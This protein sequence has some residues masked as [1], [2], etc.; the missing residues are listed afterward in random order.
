MRCFDTRSAVREQ[1]KSMGGEF[2]EVK[3]KEEGEGVG[4]YAKEMSPEFIKAEMELFANQCK[5]IDILITTALIPG[6]PAPKLISKEM[7]ASMR[8][9]SVIVDLAAEAGGNVETIKPGEMFTDDRGVIHIG[10]TDLP[11]R[12]PT[13]ASFLYANNISKLLLSMGALQ[14]TM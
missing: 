13:Q 3:I 9:G 14:W 8:P 6:K 10:Y 1:V 7:V 11:S 5:D 4:G 2:L 12:M